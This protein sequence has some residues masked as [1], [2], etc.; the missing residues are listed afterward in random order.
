MQ[1]PYVVSQQG[2]RSGYCRVIFWASAALEIKVPAR[3][4]K[5]PHALKALNTEPLTLNTPTS[6]FSLLQT[7][8]EPGIGLVV[9]CCLREWI[10][11]GF[12]HKFWRVYWFLPYLQGSAV[13]PCQSEPTT[14]KAP[15]NRTKSLHG[16]FPK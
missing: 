15:G 16:S 10:L 3:N 6:G 12:Q 2:D 8:K 7:N 14:K 9:D 13:N 4:P 1:P 5:K 11:H